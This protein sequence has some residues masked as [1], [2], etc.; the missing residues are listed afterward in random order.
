MQSS[1]LDTALHCRSVALPHR[2]SCFLSFC[3]QNFRGKPSLRLTWT[4]SVV[5]TSLHRAALPG[6]HSI[7]EIISIQDVYEFH[8]RALFW[9][10]IPFVT[11]IL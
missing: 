2:V 3:G 5:V 10:K 9:T 1:P 11:G 7:L 6:A 4:E 8:F